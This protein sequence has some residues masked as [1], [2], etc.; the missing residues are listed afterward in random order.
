MRTEGILFII[1][2]LQIINE[3]GLHYSLTDKVMREALFYY[4]IDMA[5]NM[6][7]EVMKSRGRV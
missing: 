4:F 1:L 3:G 6:D 2:L 5:I 7:T